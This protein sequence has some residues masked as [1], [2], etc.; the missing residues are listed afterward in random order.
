MTVR[1][2]F[3]SYTKDKALLAFAFAV[4]ALVSYWWFVRSALSTLDAGPS[5]FAIVAFIL[6]VV[7]GLPLLIGT[8]IVTRGT[9]GITMNSVIIALAAVLTIAY[10][11][12]L[13]CC[14]VWL[15]QKLKK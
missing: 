12:V 7:F 9:S 5:G 13:A 8:V 10:L 15:F 4:L 1:M 6:F 2:G 11:Y 3:F 14:I